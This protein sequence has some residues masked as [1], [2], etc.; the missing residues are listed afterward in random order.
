MVQTGPERDADLEE[1]MMEMGRT[2][3]RNHS[4]KASV[5]GRRTDTKPGRV[6]MREAVVKL[7]AALKVYRR[8]AKRRAGAGH[9]SAA[10]LGPL[11]TDVVAF[12]VAR[13]V[14]DAIALQMPLTA[15]S[16]AVGKALE[17]EIRMGAVK[18][19]ARGV[20]KDAKGKTGKTSL[21]RDLQGRLKRTARGGAKR[22]RDMVSRV[23]AQVEAAVP[24]AW[25]KRD[26]LR[27]GVTMV[28]LLRVH[29]GLIEIHTVPRDGK[30]P[31]AVVVAAPAAL[32]WM[33][34]QD[35]RNEVM[36]PVYL[37]M[38]T[39]PA[40]WRDAWSG[41]YRL[42]A[43]ARTPIVKARD[44]RTVEAV[45]KADPQIVYRAVST[46]QRTPWRVNR[47][48][49]DVAAR[50]FEAGAPIAGFQ[51]RLEEPHP[52]KPDVGPRDREAWAKYTR[53]AAD[54]RKKFHQNRGRRV[55]ASKTLHLAHVHKDLPEFF[56][57]CQVDFR[58]RVYPVPFFLTYQGDDLARGLLEFAKGAVIRDREQADAFRGAGAGLFGV[59]RVA[60]AQKVEWAH[61]ESERILATAADPL[62][63]RW[64]AEAE[65]PFQFLAWA[66]EYAAWTRRPAQHVSRFRVSLDGSCNGLQLYSLLT[67]DPI[68]VA[69]TNVAPSDAPR[70][71]YQD[72][73]DR[74]T[75]RLMLDPDP[76]SAQ[77]L[78][79]LGGRIPRSYTKRPTMVLPYG[80]TFH[81]AVNYCRDTYEVDRV[82]KGWT[83]FEVLSGGGYRACT[84]LGSHVWA[85][86]G[87]TVGPARAAME[88]MR[89]VA[90]VC[91]GA[92]VPVSWTS[93]SGWP[94]VQAYTK[95]ESRRI[96][97]AVGDS[98]RF[99]RY[100]EQQNELALDQQ[101]NGLPPNFVH[102]MDAAV[103]AFA[104]C[105]ARERG[106]DSLAVI[107]DSFSILAA[108]APTMS[109]TLRE[110]L[111]DVFAVD[112]LTDFRDEVQRQLPA[113]VE[114]PPLPLY[115]DFDVQEVRHAQYVYS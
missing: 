95:Y 8:N 87:E 44:R 65:S 3:Y 43:L 2:R 19:A 59:N 18:R 102:S 22:K 1:L 37:P 109:R 60:T 68:G 58:A 104:V 113:G 17:E 96:Q 35:A 16:N 84:F 77:W 50:L 28:E 79:F 54:W 66:L 31:H 115:G 64:W 55:L 93:P 45:E 70:D 85:A 21:W 75:A 7:E 78:Q 108:D 80:G 82:A 56:Y 23:A 61:R 47:G 90:A 41:G 11:K 91:T 26:R 92:G 100:R 29:T 32:N 86:I 34:Q 5:K 71:L 112:R 53:A 110:V 4:A 62:G 94:V 38:R 12:L 46:V 14:L 20:L 51:E 107:H 106:I 105:R 36:T 63:F 76:R 25:A 9:S 40:D 10:L 6:L 15:T 33:E 27:L 24:E 81:S 67:R 48:V 114:L 83:P 74:A 52:S 89:A 97:T 88:W 42:Q 69:S 72:V 39:R 57:P 30:R 99:I 13:T 73:A 103:L 111:A 49:L 98:I 101:K